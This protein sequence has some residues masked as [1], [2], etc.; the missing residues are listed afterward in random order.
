[1]R[2]WPVLAA[3]AVLLA[4][5]AVP[6]KADWREAQCDVYPAGSDKS[7]KTLPCTFAQSQGY[8]TITREDGITYEL[9][10]VGDTP[11][12]FQDAQG[13]AVYRQSGLGDQGVIFRL[14]D[15][16]LYV[17]WSTAALQPADEDNPT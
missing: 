5:T 6:A 11:G 12:N 15:E 13:R 1:M 10:P 4:G 8:I 2:L 7:E 3:A 14:P 16:S 17:Y 9:S